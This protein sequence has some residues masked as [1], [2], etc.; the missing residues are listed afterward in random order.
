MSYLSETTHQVGGHE[1][2]VREL[3]GPAQEFHV[4]LDGDK[5]EV[6]F[7]ESKG[8]FTEIGGT[9]EGP[10]P[11]SGDLIKTVFLTPDGF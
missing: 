4:E 9:E 1:V 11:T 3:A 5:Y 7:I 10:W 8:W 2:V 6:W